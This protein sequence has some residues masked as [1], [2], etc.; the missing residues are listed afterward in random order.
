MTPR[1]RAARLT[2]LALLAGL[3]VVTGL[4]FAQGQADVAGTSPTPITSPSIVAESVATARN[5][6]PF[7]VSRSGAA[8]VVWAT[9]TTR[10]PSVQAPGPDP[11]VLTTPSHD[12]P[13]LNPDDVPAGKAT[14]DAVDPTTPV[15]TLLLSGIAP[16]PGAPTAWQREP[17]PL[18][19]DGT[20]LAAT[21]W[22]PAGGDAAFQAGAVTPEG[23]AAM[24]VRLGSP[25]TRTAIIT[26]RTGDGRFQVI[27]D[28]AASLLAPASGLIDTTAAAARLPFAVVDG[29]AVAPTT[30]PTTPATNPVPVAA[31]D[32]AGS[33][34]PVPGT[35]PLPAVRSGVLIA[36]PGGDGVLAWD[37]TAWHEEPYVDRDGNVPSEPRTPV[38]LA[39]TP[40]GDGVALLQN[41]DPTSPDRFRLYRRTADHAAWREVAITG[42]PLLSG[43]LPSSVTAVTAVPAP[44]NPLTITAGHWW[45]DL[46]ATR[47]DG[48]KVSVTV[49]LAPG[50]P[51]ADATTPEP[52]TPATTTPVA[53]TPSPTTP[54]SSTPETSPTDPTTPDPSTPT[55][56]PAPT[57]PQTA[58]ATDTFCEPT[59]A[60]CTHDL[61][62]EFASRGYRSF[63]FA[64]SGLGS[65]VLTSP[66]IDTTGSPAAR[67]A[68][69]SGGYLSLAGS[70]FAIRSGVGDDADGS[71]LTQ[72]AAFADPTLGWIGARRAVGHVRVADASS[73]VELADGSVDGADAMIAVA[74]SPPGTPPELAG[75]IAL[76]STQS[77]RR[78]MGDDT[79]WSWSN[80]S[81]SVDSSPGKPTPSARAIAWPT[82][83][84]IVVAGTEG[85][86]MAG[87]PPPPDSPQ[88]EPRSNANLRQVAGTANLDFLGLGFSADGTDGW[89]IGRDGAAMHYSA[90]SWNVTT[91][92]GSLARADLREVAYVG[93]D[94][95]VAS[96]AGLLH[97]GGLSPLVRDDAL[98]TV[99][100]RDGYG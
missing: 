87:P 79:A 59:L 34:S 77:L 98:A 32:G 52:S 99:M 70:T 26:R 53:S 66:V 51:P 6:I 29:A 38:A 17:A 42:S 69:A 37:G 15:P 92:E 89:A 41:S 8:S 40:D 75:A 23:A 20:P 55:T 9:G 73:A 86:L 54:A 81:L 3:P 83:N 82:P 46:L 45:I 14:R 10:A 24:L 1:P 5:V 80:G 90:G 39:A 4:S 13:P 12:A 65:R 57:T 50:K 27:P 96:S 58:V 64:G 7:G 25:A 22:R 91:L 35:T 95:Y 71:S 84:F 43:T 47:D 18:D 60:T 2:A 93:G 33:T 48:R 72:T 49:H 68:S 30:P 19:A 78:K 97:A 36:P 85:M 11:P 100:A 56:T 63:A 74:A 76:S 67:D 28:P 16:T 21:S 94:A 61:G 44:A 62:G 31:T 88:G